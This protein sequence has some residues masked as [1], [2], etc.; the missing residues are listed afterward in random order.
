MISPEVIRRYPFFSFMT[1]D[2]QREVAMITNEV[3]LADGETLFAIGDKAESFFLLVAGGIDLHFV[4]VD[5]NEPELRKEFMVGSVN[6]SEILGI[7]ALIEPYEMTTSAIAT[8]DCHLLEI[9]AIE[10]R[11]LSEQDQALALGLQKKV[12]KATMERLLA[13]RVQLAAATAP[14]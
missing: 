11:R 4:V 3:D 2:Q 10:L 1:P 5:E 12:A 9:N 7:S 14:E 8:Q 6:P 13:T